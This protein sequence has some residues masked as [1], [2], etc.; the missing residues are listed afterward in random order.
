[1]FQGIKGADMAATQAVSGAGTNAGV[2]GAGGGAMQKDATGAE[3]APKFGEIWQQIQ[4]KYG[5]K[6]EKPRQIKK[7]LDKDDFLKIMITQMKNQDP[8][9]PFKADQ[10]A[11]QMAQ[12]ASVEQLENLNRQVAGLSGQNK[13]IEKLAMAGMIGK[14]ITIDRQRFPHT[15]G[16]NEVL[17]FALPQDAQSVH[18]TVIGTA[19]E[20]IFEKDM[21]ALKKGE[22]SLSWDGIRTNTLP[23]KTG[24]Y[25]LKIEA[26]DARGMTMN[27]DSQ[28]TARVIG[29]S[30]EGSEPEFLVGDARTQEK[31]PLR[32]IVRI[33]DDGQSNLVPGARPLAAAAPSKPNFISYT[34]GM[35]SGNADSGKV[36]PAAAEALKR[37]Q[38]QL[39][40]KMAPR[41]SEPRQV[42]Q[43]TP[44]P[45]AAP[46]K[47]EGFPNGLHDDET[48]NQKGGE[49]R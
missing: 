13:P 35:G 22:N 32:N 14:T 33:I 17:G 16:Q 9:N 11:A 15:E 8:T 43:A 44:P 42:A 47:A 31:V 23:A 12:F 24:E 39:A 40:A 46:V 6:A 21:G 18:V 34:P 3:T 4:A 49:K 2:S 36:S 45:A 1:M 38:E 19:G 29:L 10:M 25:M 26:K 41:Q 30:F 5:G 37:F 7:T 27:I 20:P 48:S 28:G